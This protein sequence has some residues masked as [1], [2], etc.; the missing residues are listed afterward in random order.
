MC[1]C[2]IPASLALPLRPPLISSDCALA[3]GWGA[4]RDIRRRLHD[5]GSPESRHHLIPF[6]E[7]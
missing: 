6:G 7:G 1:P 2:F 5:P 4:E 3:E